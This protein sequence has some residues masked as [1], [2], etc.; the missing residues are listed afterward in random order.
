MKRI[1]PI[2]NFILLLAI[3]YVNIRL[4]SIKSGYSVNAVN[5]MLNKEKKNNEMIIKNGY[6]IDN[7]LIWNKVHIEIQKDISRK[8]NIQNFFQKLI[9]YQNKKFELIPEKFKISGIYS[10][11]Q[12]TILFIKGVDLQKISLTERVLIEK[13]IKNNIKL[14]I[15]HDNVIINFIT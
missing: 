10:I 12:K 3:I 11:G 4:F 15:D 5:T 8:M 9:D 14:F 7:K 1:K 6:Y 2:I 13:F